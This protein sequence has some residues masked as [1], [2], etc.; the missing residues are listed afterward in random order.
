M[1]LGLADGS[2]GR[3]CTERPLRKQRTAAADAQQP[4]TK[5]QM[6]K[7]EQRQPTTKPTAAP[8]AP[9]KP[10]KAVEIP[11]GPYVVRAFQTSVATED[12][13]IHKCPNSSH[14]DLSQNGYGPT[15]K[16]EVKSGPAKF[17]SGG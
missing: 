2:T 3:A 14:I 5:Q 1:G 15:L 7:P 12:S 9:V 11:S 16:R 8:V 17:R 10:W 13:S 4:R 6:P